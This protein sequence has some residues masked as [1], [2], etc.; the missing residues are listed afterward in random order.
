MSLSEITFQSPDPP[1]LRIHR[2]TVEQYHRLGEVGVITPE[3]K[4]ELLEGWI[5]EKMNQ[6]P[7]HG[8]VVGLINQLLHSQLGPEWIAR[9]QLPLT[10]GESEPEPDLVLVRG[11]HSDY[12]N[13]HPGGAD[14]RLIIEVA[15]TSLAKDRAKAAIYAAAG[16]EEYWI[17]NL[18]DKTLERL[19]QPDQSSSYAEAETLIAADT[20][21]VQI[22]DVVLKLP[23]KQL[24]EGI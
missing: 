3:D 7:A 9:C 17:V 12:R 18:N 14:C 20:V 21:E 22:D 23:L 19:T 15:D 4:V 11:V 13:R 8:F 16:I 24:F 5:V 2:F 6:R 10:L 1:P